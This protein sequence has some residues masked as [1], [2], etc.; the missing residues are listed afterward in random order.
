M[1]ARTKPSLGVWHVQLNDG[2]WFK[3][4]ARTANEAKRIVRETH[5]D[6]APSDFRAQFNPTVKKCRLTEKMTVKGDGYR[7]T[8]SVRAWLSGQT[9]GPFTSN[10]Y[11]T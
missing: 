7:E 9:S 4:F 3:V 8:K 6:M 1:P 5:Y 2:D 10:T 11:E